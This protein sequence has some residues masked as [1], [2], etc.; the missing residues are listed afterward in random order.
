MEQSG[1]FSPLGEPSADILEVV[2]ESVSGPYQVLRGSKDGKIRVYKA[3]KPQFRG[4]PIYE[5]LLRKEYGIGYTLSHPGICQTIS[6]VKHPEEGSC[7]EMEWVDGVTLDTY[8]ASRHDKGELHRIECQLCDAVSYMHSR[9]VIHRD[10]KPSNIMVT[11]NGHNV[12]IIDFSLADADSY[13]VFKQPAGTRRY[14]APELSGNGASRADSRC[15]I[16]SLGVILSDMGAPSRI[17]SRCCAE[18]PEK[19]CQDALEVKAA[20]ERYRQ[21]RKTSRV[22]LVASAV[23]LAAVVLAL[24]CHNVLSERLMRE[25]TDLIEETITSRP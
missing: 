2:C 19:R 10:L 11:H 3:L 22:V 8:L 24:T 1:F 7:I 23:A 6:F 13:S 17:V 14:A 12:K 25:A 9:Q 4:D 16:W 20:L 21:R 5:A 15:D 18:D